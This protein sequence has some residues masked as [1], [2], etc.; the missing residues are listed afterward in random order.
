MYYDKIR[1]LKKTGATTCVTPILTT[2]CV[3]DSKHD[4]DIWL[5]MLDVISD[6]TNES[7]KPVAEAVYHPSMH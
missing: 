4:L 7:Y 3:Q 6:T 1:I 2:Y 5:H